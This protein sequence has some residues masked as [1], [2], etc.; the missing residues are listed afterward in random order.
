M[1]VSGRLLTVG[2]VVLLLSLA[3]NA[4]L[5]GW[6]LGR[7]VSGPAPAAAPGGGLRAAFERLLQSLPAGDRGA[8]RGAFEGHRA[9]I[10]DDAAAL[11]RARLE[12]SRLIKA[13]S[14]DVAAVQAAMQVVRE[15]TTALQ[16][17]VQGV[18]LESL[19]QLSAQGRAV[20][21]EPRWQRP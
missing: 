10:L 17:G 16:L 14:V 6:L 4:F 11:R 3:G 19:P 9:E 15:R 5:G 7:G 2:G 21:A 18:M 8:L 13:G 12:V 20:L 1:M